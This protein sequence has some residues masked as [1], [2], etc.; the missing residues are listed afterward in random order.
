MS[1]THHVTDAMKRAWRDNQTPSEAEAAKSE[2]FARIGDRL[3]ELVRDARTR[4]PGA[5]HDAGTTD[6]VHEVW[7]RMVERKVGIASTY[8]SREHFYGAC[9]VCACNLLKDRLKRKEEKLGVAQLDEERHGDVAREDP[10]DE[11]AL[12]DPAMEL[13]L[14][15][16]AELGELAADLL[17]P[18]ALPDLWTGDEI[19][20]QAA[21]DYF[22][23]TKVVQVD[24]GGFTEPAPV[25]KAPAEAVNV[26]VAEA[27]SAG[28]VWL[29]SGPASLLAEPIPTGVLQ[30]SATLRVP[31]T[32]I[33]AASILP[34][35]LPA[36]WQDG[37]TT[38]MAI[39]T[40]LSQ[41]AGVTLP[42]KTVRDVIGGSLQARF[43]SLA[44][45]SVQWPCELSA[46][47]GVKIKV[48]SAGGGTG[49]GGGGETGGGGRKPGVRVAAA[50][51]QPSQ[52]QDWGDL[53]P[54][55]LEV[56]ANAKVG[57]KFH[58][59]LEV[60]DGSTPPGEEVVND[61]NGLLA[62]LGNDFRVS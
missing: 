33:S 27:V 31:P 20:A 19:K 39:A 10:S 36:A 2:F 59:R 18:K 26:A 37:V 6:D 14:P 29:L 30:P 8:E 34:E 43:I 21:I 40:V 46:A 4:F 60:G 17:A 44:D 58:V 53:I 15:E 55:L 49:G 1:E 62:D 48:A 25:P 22:N 35:N 42:W 24:K 47:N 28:K 5:K 12:S 9:Y 41:Q 38:A 52:M 16:A 51:F 13:V 3:V 45:D 61:I 50:D 54:A 57:M 7:M 56:K 23:G 32:P 11:A